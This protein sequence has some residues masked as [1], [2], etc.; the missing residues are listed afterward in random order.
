MAIK[1]IFNILNQSLKMYNYRWR[2]HGIKNY[3][4]GAKNK[5]KGLRPPSTILVT[6]MNDG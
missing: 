6:L 4:W 1:K 3:D 5:I 2:E